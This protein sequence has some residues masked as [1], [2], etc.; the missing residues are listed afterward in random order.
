M[1]LSSALKNGI[2]ILEEN[3]VENAEFDA[4]CLFESCFGL[5]KQDILRSPQEAA[6]S[7]KS[8]L[9]LSFL[10]RRIKKEPLQYIIRE[11]D[12][13]GLR[14]K[15]G[16]GVLIPR[17]ETETLASLTL[18]RLENVACPVIFDLCA[19]TG[20]VGLAVAAKRPDA[21]V[22]LLEKNAEALYYLNKNVHNLAFPD[23]K[24]LEYDIFGGFPANLPCPGAIISNPPYIPSNELE[25]L[26]AE[27]RA[28]PKTA[29]DGGADG[30]DFYRCFA[31]KW[32]LNL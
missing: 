24:V 17:P 30:M 4:L 28:E 8:E 2:N 26:Q 18:Q 32:F 25:S 22:Y 16:P 27:V 3:G 7:R 13:F 1:T 23:T 21:E 20:C 12:F 9:F 15:V 31:G 6:D 10:Q 5:K 19:G 11:W 29:L 14:L